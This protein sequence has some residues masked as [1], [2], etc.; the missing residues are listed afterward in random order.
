MKTASE[1][2]TREDLQTETSDGRYNFKESVRPI[3]HAVN[4]LPT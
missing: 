4:V 3:C 2:R 1:N